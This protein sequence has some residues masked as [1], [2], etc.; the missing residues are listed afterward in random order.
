MKLTRKQKK[1]IKK[2]I[3]KRSLA[4]I[5][6]HLQVPSQEIESYLTK[7]GWKQKL[8]KSTKYE[9][10]LTNTDKIK[11][12][13]RLFNFKTFLKENWLVLVILIL[14]V[15]VSYTNSLG[16]EFVSDDIGG[17][18]ENKNIDK[19]PFSFAQPISLIRFFQPTISFLAYKLFGMAPFAFRLA[20]I[21]FH[22]ATVITVYMLIYL[23]SNRIT[24]IF[25]ATI[26]AVHPIMTESITWISGGGY[27]M[28]SF[29]LILAM[30]FYILTVKEKRYIYLS[31]V[32]FALALTISEK[33]V[34]F[35]FILIIL[36]VIYKIRPDNW[37]K[38]VAFL[39]MPALAIAIYFLAKL[40]ERIEWLQTTHYQEVGMANPLVQ[41]PV[42]ITSYLILIFWPN[43]LTLY[44]TELNLSSL[45]YSV[46]VGMFL[47]FLGLIIFTFKK[48]KPVF[49]WLTFFLI[50]LLPVLTPF[51]ISWIV[52]ER[53]VYLGSI[54]I[55]VT[56]SILLNKL[57]NIN[58]LKPFIIGLFS[59]TTIALC[60]RTIIRNTDWKNQ[61]SLWLAAAKTSPS[62][63]Q[64]HNNLGD[65]YG[66]HGDL[67]KAIEEFKKAIDLNPGYG[68][69]F[70]NLANI[71]LQQ[72]KIDLAIENY[73]KAT[74]INPNLW[75]SYSNL[76]GIY[77]RQENY[78]EAEKYINL[79]IEVNPN[80]SM[81]YYNLAVIYHKLGRENIKPILEKALNL[82]PENQQAKQ[83]LDSI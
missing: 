83:L 45:E 30:L 61:D 31:L 59:I 53:Y 80:V 52:A 17:I 58:N 33:A 26:T 75:Q 29:F 2:Y 67:D 34:I 3:K 62:S 9:K 28:Y 11:Q 48:N 6:S 12:N 4:E 35:P 56:I 79:A 44:H 76:S 40:P 25:A 73:K 20:N 1:Y 54:G 77:F 55:F 46:R 36:S 57:C 42:A 74:E 71:Y 66:R 68:D 39:A 24:A 60:S 63:H 49:Y 18:V 5:S 7:I 43:N 78:Q 19:L 32:S 27:C 23:L 64:N 16:N 50:S 69:A 10:S 65:M 41:I 15:F 13:I 51:G 81:S 22:L 14:L 37:K 38:M 8:I 21:T 82:D 70:H 47:T 72:R